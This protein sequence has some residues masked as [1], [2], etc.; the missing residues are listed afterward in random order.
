MRFSDTP[1]ASRR[2]L[3]SRL[4]S[5]Y[6]WRVERPE[7]SWIFFFVILFWTQEN[8]PRC[9][10]REIPRKACFSRRNSFAEYGCRQKAWWRQGKKTKTHR[11]REGRRKE[12]EHAR[13]WHSF[14]NRLSEKYRRCFSKFKRHH[15]VKRTAFL[16]LD[17]KRPVILAL[18]YR[19]VLFVW[20]AVF[21]QGSKGKEA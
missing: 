5:T 8:P 4:R 18:F 11:Q 17:S 12:D 19:L 16:S 14:P 20:D 6:K 10:C 7:T 3:I 13:K 2:G 21:T 15:E 9:S 1:G